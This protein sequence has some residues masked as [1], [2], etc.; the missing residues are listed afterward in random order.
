MSNRRRQDSNPLKRAVGGDTPA[1]DAQTYGEIKQVDAGMQTAYPTSIY[2]ILPDAKQ[3]RRQIPSVVRQ[4]WDGAADSIPTL[5]K[6]WVDFFAEESGRDFNEIEAFIDRVLEDDEISPA[7][8]Y[9]G[10]AADPKRNWGVIGGSLMAVVNL[11]AEIRRDGLTNPITVVRIGNQHLIETGERR[12]LAFHLLNIFFPDST[13]WNRIPARDVPVSSVWRQ[14]SENTARSPLNAISMARQLAI[15]LMDLYGDEDFMPFEEVVWQGVSDRA[16]YAQVA[17]GN[18]Y[19][20]PPG[21][22][23]QLVSAMGIKSPDMLRKYRSLLRL[24]DEIW[25]LADDL[26]WEEGFV[27]TRIIEFSPDELQQIAKAR[28][29]AEDVG[30]RV[31][32]ETHTVTGVTVADDEDE[33][34]REELPQAE[35]GDSLKS[36]QGDSRYSGN[37]AE[38]ALGGRGAPVKAM[39][40]QTGTLAFVTGRIAHV[41]TINGRRQ[42][43]VSNLTRAEEAPLNDD[44]DEN[45]LPAP[46]IE[47]VAELQFKILRAAYKFA[48]QG[49]LWCSAANIGAA[50]ET[51]NRMAAQGL[52][53]TK[54]T[55]VNISSTVAYYRI[56]AP[57][58]AAIN[59]PVITYREQPARSTAPV[60]AGQA[61]GGTPPAT[62]STPP[63]QIDPVGQQQRI[64]KGIL[65]EY[66]E[67]PKLIASA[68]RRINAGNLKTREGQQSGDAILE[69]AFAELR[70]LRD[71]YPD[72]E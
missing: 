16:Y 7:E 68:A 27:R 23:E 29:L 55:A 11:A 44:V 57:G 52:L 38:L 14:A 8:V 64:E 17:D 59:S 46:H 20:I 49:V 6:T 47:P 28:Q 32:D 9:Q 33:P 37:E 65:R 42:Y 45:E 25:M 36:V 21:R 40:G 39:S 62:T 34:A 50:P 58:C 19:R 10:E 43:D 53:D 3:P 4:Q 56:A 41:D 24:P 67:L 69:Q 2:D 31:T 30:Y 12:W 1:M 72:A 70:A 71:R 13:A 60:S 18:R 66:A 61:L 35:V 15:L 51:L 48:A 63:V 54:G 26:N 22:G 5:F